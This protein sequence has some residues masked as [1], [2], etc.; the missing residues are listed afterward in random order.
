M[1][2]VVQLHA[3]QIYSA[4]HAINLLFYF[5]VYILFCGLVCTFLCGHMLPGG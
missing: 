3:K 4:F 1:L 2:L 5:S